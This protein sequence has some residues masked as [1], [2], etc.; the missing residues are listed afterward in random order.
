DVLRSRPP[1]ATVRARLPPFAV[2]L[3]AR[4]PRRGAVPG[5]AQAARDRRLFIRRAVGVLRLHPGPVPRV[6]RA[7]L[8]GPPRHGG[9]GPTGAPC[10][11][12]LKRRAIDAFSSGA[13]W[14]FYGS[15]EGQFTACNADEWLARPGT[16]GRARP[17]RRLTVDDDGVIWCTVPAHAR[18]EYWRDP[19]KT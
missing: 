6:H 4:R 18:F 12:A 16:V 8:A 2:W 10:P 1:L 19:A 5:G 11:E 15:T 3:P 9:P 7:R 14:E 13:L 17:G